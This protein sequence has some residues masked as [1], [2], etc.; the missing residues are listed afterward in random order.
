M[1]P[2]PPPVKTKEEPK[3]KVEKLEKEEAKRD[4]KK[5]EHSHHDGELMHQH[6]KDCFLTLWPG[7][8]S[9]RGPADCG[10]PE[11]RGA[12]P[13]PLPRSLCLLRGACGAALLL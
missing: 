5:E 9:V 6:P 12:K 8:L 11:R 10:A 2:P 7:I 13:L 4:D 1:K 3:A